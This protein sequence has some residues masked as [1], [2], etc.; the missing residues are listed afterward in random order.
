MISGLNTNFIMKL[1][2]YDETFSLYGR[3]VQF[4]ENDLLTVVTPEEACGNG[5][6]IRP[7]GFYD[8]ALGNCRLIRKERIDLIRLVCWFD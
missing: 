8:P 7:S 5:N 2:N 1:A 4:Y 3:W 6:P